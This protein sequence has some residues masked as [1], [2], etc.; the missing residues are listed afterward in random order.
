MVIANL[1]QFYQL[2]KYDGQLL[3]IKVAAFGSFSVMFVVLF[4][5][6]IKYFFPEFHVIDDVAKAFRIKKLVD[7]NKSGVWLI[8][9]SFLSVFV[10]LVW[11]A[12]VWVKNLFLGFMYEK[13]T[14]EKVS[15]AVRLRVLRK[16]VSAGS[17]DMMLLDA[18]ESHP[19]QPVL[20]TLQ[21][22][23]VYVGIVNGILEPTENEGANSSLSI[24]PIMSGYRNKNDLSVDF[25]NVYPGEIT[26]DS[27][28]TSNS[29]KVVKLTGQM[30][31]IFS[32]EEISHISWFDFDIYDQVNNSL[33]QIQ[34]IDL[35]SKTIESEDD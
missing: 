11:V 24:F 31:I 17:L 16:T 19:K 33:K 8:L 26:T 32:A 13:N 15:H 30:D 3:Y 29:L 1:Y 23:K 7:D 35:T 5:A 14:H 28:A 4:A 27:A 10:S 25:T 20:I 6:L 2:H 12:L 9:I 22:R 18:I 34:K 21:S